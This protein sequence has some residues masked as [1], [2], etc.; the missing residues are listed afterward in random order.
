MN[1]AL[2]PSL[3]SNNKVK[4]PCSTYRIDIFASRLFL[5]TVT[6]KKSRGDPTLLHNY[7][8]IEYGRIEYN[9]IE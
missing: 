9:R 5:E 7:N 4:N 1:T 6:T 2:Y 3:Y 8:R